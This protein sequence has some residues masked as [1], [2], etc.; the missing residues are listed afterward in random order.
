MGIKADALRKNF[1]P[2]AL[3]V[4]LIVSAVATSYSVHLTRKAVGKLQALEQQRDHLYEE[5]SRLLLEQSTL[6]SF[7]EI[8]NKAQKQ[9]EMTVPQL[10]QVV[11]VSP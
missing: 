9:L 6:G 2:F 4:I 10:D 7:V 11:T 8:E 5:W 3:V 1:M